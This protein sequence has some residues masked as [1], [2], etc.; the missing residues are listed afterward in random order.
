TAFEEVDMPRNPKTKAPLND[1]SPKMYDW[2]CFNNDLFTEFHEYLVKGVKKYAPN[3]P[4]TAKQMTHLFNQDWGSYRE[5]ILHGTDFEDFADFSDI[6]GNDAWQ[7]LDQNIPATRTHEKTMWYDM[8][9]SYAEKPIYN[10]ED[11]VIYDGDTAYVPEHAMRVYTDLW[12]GAIHGRTAS[13]IWVWEKTYSNSGDWRGNILNRP[14]CVQRVGK[15][16]LD[17]NRLAKEVTAFQNSK[18]QVG[19]LYSNASRSYSLSNMSNQYNAY[20]NMMYNGQNVEIITEKTIKKIHDYK[21]LVLPDLTN[22]YPETLDEIET[23]VKNGGKVIIMGENSLKKDT[24][25]LDQN[26]EKVQYILENAVVI[27]TQNE[28][29]TMITPKPGEL[30]SKFR[31][32]LKSANMLNVEV[33][34]AKTNLP[35]SD[36]EWQTIDY[37][38]KT[39][40]NICNFKFYNDK[41]ISIK[42]NGEKCNNSKDLISLSDFNENIPLKSF[43]PMMLEIK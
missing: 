14:D 26:L 19:Q 10:A 15:A 24:Q 38:G 43:S 4:V 8:Q 12:Q 25:N 21:M 30:L 23:Y 17:M 31:D 3:I 35:V 2:L 33:V 13:T 40:I 37:N 6:M 32:A 41:E 29:Y 7:C 36:I 27:P 18:A 1:G 5:S 22:V 42:I 39:L 11:H 16:N 20:Q 9:R 34:D 28:A